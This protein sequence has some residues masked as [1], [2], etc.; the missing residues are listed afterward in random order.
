MELLE[1]LPSVATNFACFFFYETVN[2]LISYRVAH[3]NN[4]TKLKC[5]ELNEMLLKLNIKINKQN[6]LLL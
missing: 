2:Q 1:C 5:L 6:R 4:S 3:A